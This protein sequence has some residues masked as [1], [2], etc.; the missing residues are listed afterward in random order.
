LSTPTPC[1]AFVHSTVEGL[2]VHGDQLERHGMV[3]GF[4]GPTEERIEESSVA[5]VPVSY[6]RRCTSMG[7]RFDGERRFRPSARR[8][9]RCLNIDTGREW[10]PERRDPA[11]PAIETICPDCISVVI[12]ER[13]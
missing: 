11:P 6:C 13:R 9:S 2:A 7:L 3:P 5:A 4:H 10:R 12:G 8:C 1:R